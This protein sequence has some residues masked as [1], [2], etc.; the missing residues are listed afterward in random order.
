MTRLACLL[1]LIA[2]GAVTML[3]ASPTGPNAILFVF[4]GMP[5]LAAGL[6]VYGF[7]RWRAGALWNGNSREKEIP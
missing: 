2:V 4:I 1:I 7:Q 3:A 6:A 5:S